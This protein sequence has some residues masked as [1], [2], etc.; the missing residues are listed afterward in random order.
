M[1]NM[2]KSV[3]ETERTITLMKAKEYDK[4]DVLR[5]NAELEAKI[6]Y[7]QV[8][9]ENL[10]KERNNLDIASVDLNRQKSELE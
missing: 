8:D 10:V 6:K 3:E 1:I 5:K 7:M 4:V 2:S 9:T